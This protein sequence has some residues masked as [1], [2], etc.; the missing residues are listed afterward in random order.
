MKKNSSKGITP[1]VATVLL[2]T[3]S[4]AAT[5]SA[6]TF[7]TGAQKEA[8]QN[9]E[10]DL[11]QQEIRQ[12][13]SINIEYVY[14]STNNYTFMTVR[15]TGSVT[16]PVNKSGSKQLSLYADGKPVSSDVGDNGEGW[17]YV[18]GPQFPSDPV[19]LDPSATITINTTINYPARG[20]SRAFKLVG[21][22]KTSDSH[23]CYNSGTP[24]C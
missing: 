12:K 19:L 8:A 5:A 4:V 10:Q 20:E 17:K 13:S 23:V 16:L 14:N 2:I 21:S 11:R 6:Y 18:N 22:Y 9:F 24:S 7:I 15:N 1:V 3:I